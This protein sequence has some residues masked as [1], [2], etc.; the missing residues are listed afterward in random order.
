MILLTSTLLIMASAASVPNVKAATT[1]TLVVYTTLGASSIKANGTTL[2][3]GSAGNAL[4]T[5]AT[6][7]FTATAASGYQFL[8]WAY[9]DATGPSGTTSATYTKVISAACSLEAIFVPTT[10]TTVTPSGSG[11]SA[12]SLFATAGGT[13]SPA[14]SL[15]GASITGT[16]G[17]ATTITETPG[18]G[19]TFLCWVVQCSSN[20]YYTSSTLNYKPTS[21]AGAAIEALWI[22]STS[23]I[24]LP[25]V[26]P[27]PTPTKVAEFS[28]AVAAILAVALVAVAI[29]TYAVVKKNRK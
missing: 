12:I 8:G 14:G 18:T 29:G 6:Y 25:S 23:G 20:N 3:Q 21:T 4:T 5:G 27:T 1:T 9:A 28:S 19:Y 16:V 22:P 24:T 26:S 11:S 2:V 13:T 10:N 17:T 7:S 15:S